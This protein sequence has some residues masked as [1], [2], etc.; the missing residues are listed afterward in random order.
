MP[1]TTGSIVKYPARVSLVWYL[2]LILLGGLALTHPAC[3]AAGTRP[4]SLLDGIFTAT[5]AACVTGLSV[6]ST[7]QDFSFGG[8]IV[9]LLLI[10]IG[11]IGILTITSYLTIRVGGRATLRQRALVSETLGAREDSDLPW[12]LRN[13]LLATALIEGLGFTLLAVRNL[14]DMP[15]PTALWHALFHS[16]SAFCNAG[17]GL[18]DDSLTRYRADPFTNM[19]ICLLIITGG[20]GFPVMLDL[21]RQWHG[22]WRTRWDRLHLHSKVMVI[23]TAALLLFGA[24]CTLTLESDGVLRDMAPGERVLAACFHSVSSRTAGFNTVPIGELSDATLFIT[25]LL[26]MI[27]AGPCSTA[28]GFKVSTVMVMVLQAWAT[29]HGRERIRAFR[30]TIPA[31]AVQRSIATALLFAVVAIVA[32]TL[33][34]ILEQTARPHNQANGLFLDALFEVFSALGTVGLST[35]LTP[36]LSPGGRIVIIILMFLGRL[37]PISAVVALSRSERDTKVVYPGEEPLIG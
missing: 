22:P 7:E 15:V 27:G 5:S 30:R 14:R 1:K 25:V 4:I 32:L 9:I 16:I 33:L 35:G 20:L 34:L 6:R 36:A 2:A 24:F 29:F 37:G 19:V 17:F 21:R 28:G 13:V 11:G 23:G 8:Q 31:A 3:R 12:V 10:Q 18:F 26:M